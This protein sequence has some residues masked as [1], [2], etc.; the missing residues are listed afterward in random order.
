M[1]KVVVCG[2]SGRMGQIIGRMVNEAKDLELVG[3]I[4]LKASSFFGVDIVET[5][6]AEALLKKTKADVLIDFTI[7][8]AAVGNVKMA[9]RNNVALVVG[10]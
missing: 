9:A 2:A 5:K 6:D 10:T 3:G 7:A 8:T 4:D 1:I